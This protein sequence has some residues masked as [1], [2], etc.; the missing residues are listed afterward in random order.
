MA[1]T[2]L[3]VDDEPLAREGLRMLLARDPEVA[4]IHE[5]RNGREAVEAIR[6]NRPDLVFLDVQMPEMDG[7]AVAQVLG[8]EQMPAVVFVTAHDKYAIQAFEINA[9]DYLL[10]PVTEE[11]FSKALTR[12]K[13]RLQAKPGDEASRQILSLLETIA[14]PQRSLKRLAVRTAGKTIFVD[15]DEIDWMEAAENYVQL[16][17]GRAE[18]LLHVTM[19]TLEKSLDPDVFL[20]IHRSVI[21]NVRRIKELQPVMH[22]EYVVTLVNGIRLQSG[23][24]YNEKLKAL[25]ANPF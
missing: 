7:F 2:A 21:V 12:A 14:S 1:Y 10:K 15:V 24:M 19:N 17:A 23:R 18:H 9:I 20:R 6:L 16:H 3:L 4:A 22:G 13:L 25:A 8:A 11:R 5:A